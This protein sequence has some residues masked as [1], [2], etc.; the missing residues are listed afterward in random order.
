M[1]SV[2][3]VIVGFFLTAI[4]GNQLIHHWQ[5]HTWLLQQKML[6]EERDYSALAELADEISA[7][8]AR[9]LFEMMQLAD[10]I[11]RRKADEIKHARQN[12]RA[13][14][15]AWNERLPVFYANLIIGNNPNLAYVLE[16]RVQLRFVAAHRLFASAINQFEESG[17]AGNNRTR[18]INAALATLRGIATRF[19]EQLLSHVRSR[20]ADTRIGQ[21]L[22]FSQN[23][24]HYFSTW[25]LI[26]ALFVRNIDSLSI[27]R[28]PLDS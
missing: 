5:M 16:R 13:A 27:I 19:N 20:R 14:V 25:Q 24:L 9:R 23:T 18:E 6:G 26:K 21:R 12:Y 7:L 15:A 22:I 28:P 3:A 1:Y 2:L 11:Q 10:A 4:V 8:L 17:E